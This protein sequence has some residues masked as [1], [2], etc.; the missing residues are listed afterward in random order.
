MSGDRVMTLATLGG[1]TGRGIR[2]AVVDTGVHGDHPHVGGVR[3]GI[4]IAADGTPVDDLV[5]RV[6][7]GTAV[8]AAIREKAPEA[9][10]VS[11]KVFDRRLVTTSAALVAG[12]AWAAAEGVHII[13]LS[14]GTANDAHRG[15]LMAAVTRARESGAVVVAAAPQPDAVWLPGA[16]P[17]VV[18]VEADWDCPRDQCR[19]VDA[20]DGALRMTASAYPRPVPGVPVERNIRGLSVAVA[21]ASGFLALLLEEPAQWPFA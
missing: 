18:A 5:D 7:H 17:G 15:A 14:L 13:N 20:A 12:L 9:E 21:N 4:G 11:V 1:R 2:V 3:G 8:A 10:L 16:L 19:F 6:G